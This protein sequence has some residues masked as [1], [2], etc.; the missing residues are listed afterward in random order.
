MQQPGRAAS[1]AKTQRLRRAT[2]WSRRSLRKAGLRPGGSRAGPLVPSGPPLAAL[3][4]SVRRRPPRR[5]AAGRCGPPR[6]AFRGRGSLVEQVAQPS[7][8]PKDQL[9]RFAPFRETAPQYAVVVGAL[10]VDDDAGD[11]AHVFEHEDLVFAQR[12]P[13]G[14]PQVVFVDNSSDKHLVD[15]VSQHVAA[16]QGDD[17]IDTLRPRGL[18]RR[19]DKHP[20][21][22]PLPMLTDPGEGHGP[23]IHACIEE[24]LQVVRID[25]VVRIAEDQVLSPGV[26]DAVFRAAPAPRFVWCMTL[27]RSGYRAAYSS[28]IRPEVSRLPSSTSRI[29]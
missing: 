22:L 18:H 23:A 13:L 2:L 15:R 12:Q 4:G 27:T 8:Y 16:T 3:G 11:V 29:S 19:G 1:R 17:R 9:R 6:S 25:P 5:S 7:G 24:L 26:V 14:E 21:R 28:Q 20:V 10:L